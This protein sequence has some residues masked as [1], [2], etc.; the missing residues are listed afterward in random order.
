MGSESQLYHYAR[1]AFV[2]SM[3]SPVVA[4]KR[5]HGYEHSEKQ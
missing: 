4:G 2:V 3:M 1:A 5:R